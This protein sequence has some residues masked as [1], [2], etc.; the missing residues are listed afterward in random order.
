MFSFIGWIS[1]LSQVLVSCTQQVKPV[2]LTISAGASLKSSMEEIKELYTQQKPKVNIMYK[3]SSS[4]SHQKAIEE[5]AKVDIYMTAGSQFM[6]DLQSKGFVIDDTRKNFLKNRIILIAP[7][8]ATGIS[9]FKDLT[10]NKIKKVAISNPATGS[11]GKYAE[12]ILQFF[13]ILE[14]VKPK[15]VFTKAGTDIVSLLKKENAN[16]GIIY[17]TD[18]IKVNE[19]KIVAIAPENSHSPITYT[20]AVLKASKNIPEAKEFVQFLQSDRAGSV[21][22]KYGFAIFIDQAT[23]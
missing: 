12:E 10:D 9:K 14:Q 22:V 20:V 13:G 3:F 2:V 8:N 21:F 17:A 16:A 6:D 19:I 5:G 4:G 7:K 15:F 18:A 23:Q 1:I 11:S